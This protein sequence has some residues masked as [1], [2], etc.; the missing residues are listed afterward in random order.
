MKKS[1]YKY[2]SLFAAAAA[3]A[4][5]GAAT[6]ASAAPLG[7]Y[8]ATTATPAA[9]TGAGT[10]VKASKPPFPSSVGAN[11]GDLS[12][13]QMQAQAA[14]PP[15]LPEGVTQ[16]IESGKSTENKT[17][18]APTPKG[19]PMYGRQ[20]FDPSLA[21]LQSAPQPLPWAS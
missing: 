9:A 13:A 16:W 3:V 8:G 7:G 6:L 15:R 20:G 1:S 10:P 18:A 12:R 11:P 21:Q 2:P 5:V 19:A 4:L 17:A 14:P